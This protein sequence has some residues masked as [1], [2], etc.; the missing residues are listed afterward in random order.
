MGCVEGF[1]SSL[2]RLGALGLWE[3]RGGHLDGKLDLAVSLHVVTESGIQSEADGAVGGEV[4]G[5]DGVEA[6]PQV[7]RDAG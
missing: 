2:G 5:V 3:R 4:T 7:W 6:L 1:A